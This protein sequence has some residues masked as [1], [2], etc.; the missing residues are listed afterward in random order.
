MTSR[1]DKL[2]IE[3]FRRKYKDGMESIQFDR[4]EFASVAND[5]G[6]KIPKNLGDIIY[7]YRFRTEL[8]DEITRRAPVGKEWVI[9]AKGTAKYVFE[10]V[11]AARIIPDTSLEHIKIPDATPSVIRKYSLA[12]EQSLLNKLRYNRLLDIFLGVTCYSLQNHLRTTVPNVGQIEVDELYIGIDAHGKR[13]A[14]PVQA[15]GNNDVIGVVQVEQDALMCEH[16]FPSLICRPIVVQFMDDGIIAII[17]CRLHDGNVKK[18]SEKHYKIIP[19]EDISDQELLKY[20]NAF[21]NPN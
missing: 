21:P 20:R 17:E 3:I 6:I 13:Y 5:S 11:S 19:E 16:K 2:I 12:D 10:A 15:K 18:A 9:K 14:I 8:P 4:E 1:Y 7:S